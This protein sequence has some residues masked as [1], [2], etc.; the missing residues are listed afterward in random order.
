[1]PS[2]RLTLQMGRHS[3]TFSR[4]VPIFVLSKS[5]LV[6]FLFIV[7]FAMR[8]GFPSE[9]LCSSMLHPCLSPVS[10]TRWPP[11]HDGGST[12]TTSASH[13]SLSEILHGQSQLQC[14]TQLL[15][16]F[17]GCPAGIWQEL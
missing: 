1:M 3:M 4:F 15:D 8:C 9:K 10:N 6:K 2:P 5:L 12:E 13:I 16:V 7:H 17:I 14:V 11:M